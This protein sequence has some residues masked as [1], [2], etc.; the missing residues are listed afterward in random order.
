MAEKSYTLQPDEKATHVILGTP[1]MLLWGDLVTKD[2]IRTSGFLNTL[3]EDFVPLRDVKILFLAPAQQIA[4]VDRAMAYV[5][6]EEILLFFDMSHAEPIPEETEVRRFEPVEV[7]VGSFQIDGSILKSPIATLQNLL[8]V[9]K[10]IY[11]PIY[12]ATIRHVAKP[13]LGAFAT[14]VVLVRRDRF[15][16]TRSRM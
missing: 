7:I 14:N 3:A 9:S 12:K 5:K 11:L 4:P 13:W 16:M 10:D 8:L 1:D 15:T 2:H 6:L